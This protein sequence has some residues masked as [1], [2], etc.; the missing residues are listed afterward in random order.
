ML[1]KCPIILIKCPEIMIKNPA[2][3]LCLIGSFACQ[4]TVFRLFWCRN[5]TRIIKTNIKHHNHH[6]HW[7][8]VEVMRWKVTRAWC[9]SGR[10]IV[11]TVLFQVMKSLTL[12]FQCE[13][14][15]VPF[16]CCWEDRDFFLTSP[17]EQHCPHN[18]HSA[19]SSRPGHFSSH[20]LDGHS[21]EMTIVT[22]CVRLDDVCEVSTT[23]QPKHSQ[24]TCKRANH[25]KQRGRVFYH[26]FGTHYQ[27]Y[28]T[29]YQHFG[30]E[31]FWPG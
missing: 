10:M 15:V 1:I 11:R 26:N 2:S 12:V 9:K 28:G 5:F 22:F 30:T 3:F 4:L 19:L 23:K 17:K 16:W 6:H 21:T 13:R 27:D 31:G 8:T 25:T 24:L 14:S 20:H 18:H 7:M 29:H